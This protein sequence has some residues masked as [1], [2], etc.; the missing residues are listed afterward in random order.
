MRTAL[1]VLTLI[2]LAL[3]AGALG[4]EPT[5]ASIEGPG[6]SATHGGWF[7]SPSKPKRTLV[8]AGLPETPPDSGSS[9]VRPAPGVAALGLLGVAA[10][11]FTRRRRISS[12]SLLGQPR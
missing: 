1:A 2:V 10:V 5:Q 12:G 8:A 9:L 4:K 7:N 6:V 11:V 3:P